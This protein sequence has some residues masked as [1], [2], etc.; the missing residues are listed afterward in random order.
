[1]PHDNSVFSVETNR[2]LL[3]FREINAVFSGNCGK[4]ISADFVAISDVNVM[5]SVVLYG[6]G[7]FSLTLRKKRR[8]KV[9]EKRVLRGIFALKRDEVRE[10]LSE[11]SNDELNDLYCSPNTFWVTKLRRMRWAGHVML[12]VRGETYTGLV[13][14]LGEG[15]H[16]GDQ[17]V[18]GRIILR[19]IFRKWDFGLRTGSSW[20][21]IGTGGGHL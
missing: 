7:T 4:H 1:M 6:C 8:L 17:S 9:F 20:L 19:W 5:L 18:D 2:L 21:K 11:H 3:L 15:D 16:L 14:K 10:E 13:G 12:M